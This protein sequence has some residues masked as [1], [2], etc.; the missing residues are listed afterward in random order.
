MFGIPPTSA[1]SRSVGILFGGAVLTAAV[2]LPVGCT[3]PPTD[4]GSIGNFR[5]FQD[6]SQI[7]ASGATCTEAGALAFGS[8]GKR[9]Q[10]YGALD[11]NCPQTALVNHSY[12]YRCTKF[13]NGTGT[14]TFTATEFW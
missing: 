1:R 2:T 10:L 9:G 11:Y 13:I 4:R 14:I 12:A 7:K 6:A 8:Q 5:S 3:T